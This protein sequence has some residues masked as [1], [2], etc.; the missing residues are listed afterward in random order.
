MERLIGLR[1]YAIWDT[2][3]G[4][5]FYE[6][7]SDREIDPDLHELTDY[8]FDDKLSP[9]LSKT[10]K[11]KYKPSVY[12]PKDF[13]FI[14]VTNENKNSEAVIETIELHEN[15]VI[16]RTYYDINEPKNM[17]FITAF[18]WKSDQRVYIVAENS[19]SFGNVRA[20]EMDIFIT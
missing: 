3:S 2:I 9:K 13:M 14:H 17:I 6:T 1:V 12:S 4:N 20:L 15:G 16:E 18:W 8:F 10:L 7:S 11:H 19:Q 5:I